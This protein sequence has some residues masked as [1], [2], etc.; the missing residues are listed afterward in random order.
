[1]FGDSLSQLCLT[2]C[3]NLS[4]GN[5]VTATCVAPSGCQ[6]GYFADD[7]TNLCVPICPALQYT[8][9][10]STSRRCVKGKI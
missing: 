1:M 7:S 3:P 2:K 6:T 5:A 8:F 9:G 4:Y 10:E